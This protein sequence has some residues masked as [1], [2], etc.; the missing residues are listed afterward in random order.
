MS[1]PTKQVN[2]RVELLQMTTAEL[3]RFIEVSLFENPVLVQVDTQVALS[4]AAECNVAN[5]ENG[6]N[7][8]AMRRASQNAHSINDQVTA[9]VIP[10]LYIQKIDGD[11]DVGF[12]N[13]AVSLICIDQKYQKMLSKPETSNELG[14][15]IKQ[16]MRAAVELLRNMEHR[17]TLSYEVVNAIARYQHEFLE[18]GTEYIKPMM[19]NDLAEDTGLSALFISYVI[20]GK[21]VQTPHGVVE[22]R[23]FF[24]DEEISEEA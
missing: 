12:V 8:E 7:K 20:D 24:T 4:E 22:L 5:Q 1:D 14:N 17:R 23:C 15:A 13:D 2:Q 6:L 21:Y 3:S 19:L 18:K 16:K 10:E 11:Y 9:T